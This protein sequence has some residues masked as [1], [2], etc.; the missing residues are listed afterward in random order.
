MRLLYAPSGLSDHAPFSKLFE[1]TH[2]LGKLNFINPKTDLIVFEGGTDIESSLY[3][4]EPGSHNEI[5]NRKRDQFEVEIFRLAVQERIPMLGICRGAQLITALTGGKL[6]QH[7]EGHRGSY[8]FIAFTGMK[9][10]KVIK[11]ICA[12]HQACVPTED[13]KI[14]AMSIPDNVPEI[15]WY[16]KIKAL[17]IQGHPAW[18]KGEFTET[19]VELT[20]SLLL[21]G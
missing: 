4:E 10:S 18:G 3:G 19:C 14:L 13:A 5:P 1:S 7:M 11:G 20:S 15:F 9:K 12:H 21:G 16:P 17:C 8:P 2:A 6:I